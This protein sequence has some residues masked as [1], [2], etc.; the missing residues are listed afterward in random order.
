MKREYSLL[1][2]GCPVVTCTGTD[3][4]TCHEV[5]IGLVHQE[6]YVGLLALG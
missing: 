3:L 2:V 1:P 4:L 6:E 5:N